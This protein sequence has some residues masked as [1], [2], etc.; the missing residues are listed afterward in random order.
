MKCWTYALALFG[1]TGLLGALLFTEM[2]AFAG[3]NNGT[4]C[5]NPG[6][7][8]VIVG[9]IRGTSNYPSVGGIEAFAFGTE[10]CNIGDEEL[11]W[12]SGTNENRSSV[13]LCIGSRMEDLRC[14]GRGG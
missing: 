8:D 4:V 5:N 9:D 1:G 14:S 7:P 3:G 2:P 13:S 12:Y 10:S 6:G 11:W